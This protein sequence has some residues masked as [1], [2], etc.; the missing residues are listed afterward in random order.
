MERQDA[1]LWTERHSVGLELRRVAG[2]DELSR[3]P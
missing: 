1:R 3:V 2:L